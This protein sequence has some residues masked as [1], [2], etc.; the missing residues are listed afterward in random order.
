MVILQGTATCVGIRDDFVTGT[1]NPALRHVASMA[2][3]SGRDALESDDEMRAASPA[4]PDSDSQPATAGR[5]DD[6][7]LRK[8][9]GNVKPAV[10]TSATTSGTTSS[11]ASYVNHGSTAATITEHTTA[12]PSAS[13]GASPAARTGSARKHGGR[14]SRHSSAGSQKDRR[15]R[16]A[17]SSMG[18]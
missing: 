14:P 15:K 7:L 1:A 5:E 2:T 18:F 11:T 13:A 9:W 4:A 10:P 3:G 6:E 8:I 12:S 17:K 16:K